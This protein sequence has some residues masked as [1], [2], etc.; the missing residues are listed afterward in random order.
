[1]TRRF[2]Y[3]GILAA[4]AITWALA[5]SAGARTL[6]DGDPGRSRHGLGTPSAREVDR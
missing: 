1:M 5:A 3:G 4:L 6:A 2:T